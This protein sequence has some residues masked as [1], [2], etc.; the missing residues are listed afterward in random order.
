[1]QDFHYQNGTK[2]I[3]GRETEA[4]VGQE[5]KKFTNKVLLH[6]GG[7]SIKKIGLYDKVMHSLHEAGIEVFELGGVKPNPRLSLVRKGINLCQEQE[8]P[9]ILAVGGGSVIDSAKAIAA[10]VHYEGDVWDL[11]CGV[12]VEHEC[13]PL[14][15]ILTIP[16]AG[17]EISSGTVVTNDE[18]GLKRS[19]GHESLRPVFSILNPELT[20]TLPTYQTACGIAD[21]LAHVLERYFTNER[22]VDIT[23]R[24][25]E[26]TM[27][28]IIDNGLRV[29]NDPFNYDIRAELMLAGMI[30]HNGSLDMGRIGDWA[31][32]DIEH[33]LSGMYD[34]AH[35]AGLAI[36]FPAWMK[37]VYHHD[38]NRFAQFGSRVFNLE[39]NLNHPEETALLAIEKLESFFKALG[40]PTSFSNADLPTDHIEELAQKLVC[41]CD[42][43]GNYVPIKEAD[44][45]EIYRLAL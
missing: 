34:I 8:I 19:F 41:D 2:I 33:E 35:G 7:G 10:G 9:F 29:M 37:Y 38:V 6:Y 32:H 44:A 14:A 24:L 30:A 21:M 36:I 20:F 1:M 11:F 45:L 12:A 18:I 27:K 3:F 13:L 17:S 39:I 22:H 43:V 28:S 26:A 5:L 15:T 42:S 16:A 40:L 25:C 4:S 23:D 31:S